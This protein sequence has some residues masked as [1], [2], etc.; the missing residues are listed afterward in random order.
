[1]LVN[2]KTNYYT[3]KIANCKNYQ[4]Q[5]FNITRNL[6]GNTD[7]TTM[8]SYVCLVDMAQR[9]GDHF[10]D[11]MSN[12]RKDIVNCVEDRPYTTMAAVSND[13]VFG[14]VPL[15]CFDTVT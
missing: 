10:I 2:V 1:M 9:F 11:K 12:I 8:P 14:G 6:V 5:L 15:V 4:K 13:A 3:V 7:I